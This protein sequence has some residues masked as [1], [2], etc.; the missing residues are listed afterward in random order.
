MHWKPA[1]SFNTNGEPIY[2]GGVQQGLSFAQACTSCPPGAYPMCVSLHWD[3][4]GARGLE[5]APICV[6]VANINSQAVSTQFCLGYM[7]SMSFVGK[8]FMGSKDATELKL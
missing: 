8:T 4:T 1:P 6:G 5:A 3:G 2:G 7:P